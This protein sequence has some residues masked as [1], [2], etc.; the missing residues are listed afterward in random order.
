MNSVRE[1]GQRAVVRVVRRVD[2]RVG[3]R[4]DHVGERASR[5]PGTARSA[6]SPASRS[7]TWTRSAITTRLPWC[8]GARN[9][10]GGAGITLAI[11][12]SSSGAASAA[13]MKPAIVSAVAGRTSM[14]PTIVP[15]SWSRYWKRVTTPKLPPPPR[16]AQNRSGCE[17]RRRR[18]AAARRRSRSRP[19]A[20]SRSSG[21]ACGRGSRPRRR[22]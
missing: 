3:H 17:H 7:P 1:I 20:A 4:P 5:G 10:I 18:G 19:R 12:E 9:G 15:T 11:V 21:R 14:P 2:L 8:S 22:G 6:R 16:I 13:A